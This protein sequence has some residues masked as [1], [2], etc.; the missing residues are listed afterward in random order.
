[1]DTEEPRQRREAIAAELVEENLVEEAIEGQP[2][3]FLTP[4]HRAEVGVA[5]RLQALLAGLEEER[6]RAR[7]AA[8][9]LLEGFEA[10]LRQLSGPALAPA[11]ASAWSADARRIRAV[12]GC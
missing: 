9:V 2:C 4:L 7:R 1:M 8:C 6:P 11:Q 5:Q 12:L 3:L 10:A